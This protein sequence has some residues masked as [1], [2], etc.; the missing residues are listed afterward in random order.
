MPV[1]KASFFR[2]K[3]RSENMNIRLNQ[4]EISHVKDMATKYTKGNI[5]AWIR[6][7]ALKMKPFA[8]DLETD[9]EK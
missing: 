3:G 6:Y 7:A 5:S 1:I 4:E 8:R 2:S 9:S